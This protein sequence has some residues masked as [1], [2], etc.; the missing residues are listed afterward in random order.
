MFSY[1]HCSWRNHSPAWQHNQP[2]RGVHICLLTIML[3]VNNWCLLD[4]KPN[5]PA[6]PSRLPGNG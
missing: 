3:V 2:C 5:T 4:A 6:S 1:V